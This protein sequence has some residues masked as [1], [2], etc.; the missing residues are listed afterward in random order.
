M[1]AISEKIRTVFPELA[2]LKNEETDRIFA[3]RNLPSFVKDYIIKR[4][5]DK[6]GVIDLEAITDYLNTKMCINGGEIRRKLI[7]GQP[8]SQSDLPFHC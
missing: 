6:E 1:S 8:A 4:F 3:G 2:I 5:S 7:D